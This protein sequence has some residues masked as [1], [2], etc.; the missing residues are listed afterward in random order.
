MAATHFASMALLKRA[1]RVDQISQFDCADNM[2][3]MLL[4]TFTLQAK[5][6]AKLQRGGKQIVKVVHVHQSGQAI[7][8]NESTGA[9][10]AIGAGGGVAD[11][12]RN[13]PHEKAIEAVAGPPAMPPMWRQDEERDTVPVTR[14]EG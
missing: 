14:G 4:R 6:F 11:E 8:G 5:A 9:N 7:V 1:M 12:N 10:G 2:T 3:V 13:Q